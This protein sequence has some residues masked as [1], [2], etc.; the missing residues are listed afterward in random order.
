M[1]G[2]ASPHHLLLTD[3]ACLDYDTMAKM[4]PPLRRRADIAR[5]KEGIADGTITVLATDH[6]PHTKEEKQNFLH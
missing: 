1:T 3:E 4:N 6:A 2:E 5:L